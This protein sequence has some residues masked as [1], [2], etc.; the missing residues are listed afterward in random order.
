M[1]IEV[2]VIPNASISAVIN[3]LSDGAM[4]VKLQVPAMEGK[5]NKAL[6]DLLA[7]HFSINKK[8]VKIVLGE[9]SRTKVVEVDI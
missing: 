9:K 3:D 2:T 4:K 1:R 8:S 6:I 7:K 5:A